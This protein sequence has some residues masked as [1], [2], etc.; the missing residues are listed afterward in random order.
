MSDVPA[1]LQHLPKIATLF[2]SLFALYLLPFA[3]VP[4]WNEARLSQRILQGQRQ[5][6][7][8]L[9][10]DWEL[11]RRQ[12]FGLQNDPQAWIRALD[13]KGVPPPSYLLSRSS[14]R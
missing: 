7:Q 13:D 10:K 4:A 5:K 1:L 2:F 6:L 8:D 3:L 12:L 11:K 14:E 9:K